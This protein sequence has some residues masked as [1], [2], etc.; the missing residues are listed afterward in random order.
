MNVLLKSQN[1]FSMALTAFAKQIGTTQV[2]QN[3]LFE[4]KTTTRNK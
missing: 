3:V 1:I 2:H 4:N